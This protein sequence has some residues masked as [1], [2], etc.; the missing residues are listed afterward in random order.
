MSSLNL[1]PLPT[2]AVAEEK[3]I[4]PDYLY[5]PEQ[6]IGLFDGPTRIFGTPGASL[7]W[8]INGV[9]NSDVMIAGKEGENA[10][11]KVLA[12]LSE[13]Q[14]ELFVFHSLRWPESNGDTDHAIVYKNLVIIIDTKRW[15][16]SRKYSITLNGEIKRGTVAFPEG[17]VKIGGALQVWRRKIPH[18]LIKGVVAIAQDKV[19]VVRDHNWFKAPYRLVEQEKLIEYINETIKKHKIP[20]D[21]RNNRQILETFASLLV[22]PRDPRSGL[23]QGTTENPFKHLR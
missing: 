14:P 3:E 1:P 20:A 5:T 12:E 9:R 6:L 13:T 2:R 19:F 4:I 8:G 16:G 22:K 23:I 17:K 21:Y 11:G 10:T 7:T 15:K 18:A